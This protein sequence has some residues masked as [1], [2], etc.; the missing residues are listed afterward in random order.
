MIEIKKILVTTDLSVASHSAIEYAAWLSKKENASVT[1]FYS[2]D[3]LPTVAYHTV[4]LTFDKFREEILQYERK[5]LQEY[6]TKIGGSFSGKLNVVLTE[7]NAAQAIVQHA[8]EEKTDIIIMNTLWT[9]RP[10][11]HA[12]WKCGRT[13]CSDSRMSCFNS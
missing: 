8:K 4:D 1:L 10:S 13:G 3:N 2:V 12:S 5:H 7:G 9:D 6:V 11:A